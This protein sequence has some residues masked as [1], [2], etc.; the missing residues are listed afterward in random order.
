VVNQAKGWT[1]FVESLQAPDHGRIFTLDQLA[2]LRAERKEDPR[3]VF[4]VST[5]QNDAGNQT[6]AC[7]GCLETG[8]VGEGFKGRARRVRMMLGTWDGERL[9]RKVGF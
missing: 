6:L 4:W 2:K 5:L 8:F 7:A 9:G 3:D 1:V